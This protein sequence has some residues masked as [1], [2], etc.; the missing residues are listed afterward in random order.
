MNINFESLKK[1]FNSRDNNFYFKIPNSKNVIIHFWNSIMDEK[2]Q[3]IPEYD[4]I[5]KWLEDN[6]GTGL[7]LYGGNGRGKTVMIEV[8]IPAILFTFCKKIIA[9]TSAIKLNDKI[10]DKLVITD[11][12]NKK[13]LSIDDIGK[14][15][16]LVDYGNIR[17]AFAEIMDNAEKK[18]N[19]ILATSNL[20]GQEL[21]AKYDNAVIERIKAC[22]IRIPFDK[23]QKSFRKDVDL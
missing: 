23:K 10:D 7:F 11:L 22:C 6:K 14:E 1:Q 2:I 12:L 16:D 18:G 8:I 3:W 17:V 21:L 15:G 19:F 13:L 9:Q 5:A 20:D 4:K